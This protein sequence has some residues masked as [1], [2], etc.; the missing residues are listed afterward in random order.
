MVQLGMKV[1]KGDALRQGDVFLTQLCI[2]LSRIALLLGEVSSALTLSRCAM[3]Q[4]RTD[5]CLAQASLIHARSKHASGDFTDALTHYN[6]VNCL[7]QSHF[8]P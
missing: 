8:R 3:S 7:P 1:L 5:E 4:A 2:L 6:H